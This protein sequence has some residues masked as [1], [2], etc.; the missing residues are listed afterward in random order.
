MRVL[1]LTFAMWCMACGGGNK[2]VESTAPTPDQIP[3]TAGPEC[4]AVG[5]HL[6][7]LADHDA[8]K[9]PDK[10]MGAKLTE[11]CKADA[12]TD[13]ARS[14]FATANTDDEAEGCVKLL[15]D[16]Q[17]KVFTDV[18]KKGEPAA[19]QS[20][21]AAAPPKEAPKTPSKGTTRGAT[22]KDKPTRTG[23]PCQGGE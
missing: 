7:T 12:W 5:E 14:C 21:A 8:V 13:E 3:R 16:T 15:T 23:D 22:K 17:K 10:A 2:K 4:S 18:A 11:H 19:V 6:A 1:A 9:G 20:D